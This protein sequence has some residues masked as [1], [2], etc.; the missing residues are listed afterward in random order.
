MQRLTRHLSVVRMTNRTCMHLKHNSWPT[1]HPSVDCVELLGGN[2]QPVTGRLATHPSNATFKMQINRLAVQHDSRRPSTRVHRYSQSQ[3]TRLESMRRSYTLIHQVQAGRLTVSYPSSVDHPPTN[4]SI[5][6]STTIP[7]PRRFSI[8]RVRYSGE[9]ITLSVSV[10]ISLPIQRDQCVVCWRRLYT[11]RQID[12]SVTVIILCNAM[13]CLLAK[14]VSIRHYVHGF[15][16]ADDA[17]L[18]QKTYPGIWW[19]S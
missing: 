13:S 17:P 2:R 14:H 3:Q 1:P 4:P 18:V 9:G 12:R 7:S 16:P 11:T 19:S 10:L 5:H 8:S 15:S 6:P